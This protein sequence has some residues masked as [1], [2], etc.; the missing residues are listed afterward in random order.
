M[1]GNDELGQLI[2]AIDALVVAV[3]GWLDGRWDDTR[4]SAPS[5]RPA[6]S[7]HPSLSDRSI[8]SDHPTSADPW[9]Q[10]GVPGAN[11]P[12]RCNDARG[13][14]GSPLTEPVDGAT[15]VTLLQQSHRL[16]ALAARAA[17]AFDRS[18]TWEADGA[19]SAPTWLAV[20]CRL[21]RR[22][23]ARTVSLGATAEELP[24]LGTAW[25][26]GEVGAAHVAAIAPLLG[27]RTKELVR[28]DDAMLT[29]HARTLSYPAFRQALAYWEQHADPDGCEDAELAR[30][31]R[32]QVS[33]NQSFGGQWFG[34]LVLDPV[35]GSIVAD[36]LARIEQQLFEADLG[37]ARARAEADPSDPGDM[38]RSPTQRRADALVAMATR[39]AAAGGRP[40]PS[41]LFTVL[42]DFDTLR[43]RICELANGQVLAPGAI[44]P[45]LTSADIERVVRQAPRRLEVSATTR[46]FKGATRRALEVLDRTCTHR[47]C[48]MPAQW[49]QGDHIVRFADG[50]PTVQENGRLLCAYHNRLRELQRNP[51]R[52]P[53][54]HDNDDHHDHDDD[55]HD[56]HDPHDHDDDRHDH[57]DSCHDHDHGDHGDH[58]DHNDHRDPNDDGDHRDPNDHGDHRDPNDDGDHHEPRHGDPNEHGD[59]DPHDPHDPHDHDEPRHGDE[60]GGSDDFS[61]PGTSRRRIVRHPRSTQE[62]PPPQVPPRTFRTPPTA[63]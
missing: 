63:A 4:A 9:G 52:Q 61:P 51:R 7:D 42:V 25:T 12:G 58:G 33:L 50:G 5:D 22:D 16:Q 14:G 20:E 26:R 36:E 18:R 35:G 45:W 30:Q 57:D 13:C 27:P 31:A 48:D 54:G 8:P 38:R 29:D 10:A 21:P 17:A 40:L 3:D 56:H 46:L 41:P 15:V 44:A 34:N 23:V 32:R 47:Y 19:R 2:G 39:S 49:C 28:R 37:E 24:H 1:A 11:G 53:G 62:E 6:P 59:H 43:G 60:R 55:P